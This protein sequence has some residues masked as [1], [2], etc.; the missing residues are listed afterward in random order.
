M[1]QRIINFILSPW[2]RWQEHRRFKQRIK[3]LKEQD[4]YIYK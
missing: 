2:H 3:E 1:V 4:P